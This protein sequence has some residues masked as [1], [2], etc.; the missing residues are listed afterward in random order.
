MAKKNRRHFCAV[1][2][3]LTAAGL[4]SG[5]LALGAEP[6]AANPPDPALVE[7]A[8]AEGKVTFYCAII[9]KTARRSA[10]LFKTSTG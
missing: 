9:P 7:A 10:G 5:G 3:L 4:G 2:G 6:M 1:L 8:K